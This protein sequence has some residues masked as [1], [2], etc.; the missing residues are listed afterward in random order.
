MDD[1]QPMSRSP[2]WESLGL[3][4][5][6]AEDENLEVLKSIPVFSDVP[7][8][9]LRIIRS[10]FHIRQYNEDEHIFRSGEPGVGM[11]IILE[12]SVEIYRSEENIYREYAVL[13]DGNFFGEIA[14]LDDLP[15]TASARARSYCTLLGFYRP[16][17]LDLVRRNPPLAN[18]ILMNI[19]R[20]IGRRLVSTN[21]ELEKLSIQL[22][23]QK[24]R[25][26]SVLK[27]AGRKRE[28]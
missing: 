1:N 2:L 28:D 11:Y 24:R 5:S 12:G 20:L 27:R 9:G 19:A 4:R 3:L 10:L 7:E 22:E 14:L 23:T 15:R 21:M 17:L 8:K 13:Y 25:S 18:A 6:K 16:D 26:G